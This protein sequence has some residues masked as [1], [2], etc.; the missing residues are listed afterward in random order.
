M[1]KKVDKRKALISY[2]DLVLAAQSEVLQNG[3][4]DHFKVLLNNLMLMC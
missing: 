1:R 4:H 3:L 2:C